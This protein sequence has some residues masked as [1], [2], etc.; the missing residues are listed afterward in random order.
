LIANKLMNEDLIGKYVLISNEYFYFG[1]GA[2]PTDKFKIKVP[3]GQAKYG[4]KTTDKKGIL[5]LWRYLNK[6]FK[7]NVVLNAPMSWALNEPFN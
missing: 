4:S 7:K 1:S 2:I 3:K 5:G 6:S